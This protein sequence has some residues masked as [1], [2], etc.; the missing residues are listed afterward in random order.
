ME[1]KN[2]WIITKNKMP[3]YL[4]IGGLSEEHAKVN[5]EMHFHSSWATLAGQGFEAMN[6]DIV[7]KEIEP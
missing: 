4:L 5:L 6:V 3:W 2:Y 7:F 1:R